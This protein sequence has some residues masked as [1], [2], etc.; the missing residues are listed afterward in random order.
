MVYREPGA[1]GRAGS[2]AEELRGGGP[3]RSGSGGSSGSS[4]RPSDANAVAL[5]DYGNMHVRVSPISEETAEFVTG[6]FR[7][8]FYILLIMLLYQNPSL[9]FIVY[10]MKPVIERALF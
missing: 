3:G 10:M 9:F 4:S 7:T 5:Q 2:A 1:K 8:I 6:I